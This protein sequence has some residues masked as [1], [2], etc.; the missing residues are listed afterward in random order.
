MAKN[1]KEQY[2]PT[3]LI[4]N[5]LLPDNPIMKRMLDLIRK[6]NIVGNLT[7]D[8]L[9]SLDKEL[10][11]EF[12]VFA[13]ENKNRLE[14]K[15]TKFGA[16]I[17]KQA[18]KRALKK[19]ETV[20]KLE[21]KAKPRKETSTSST[22]K[23][24]VKSKKERIREAKDL[25]DYDINSLNKNQLKLIITTAG[26]EYKR[27]E[28]YYG[29]YQEL[30]SKKPNYIKPK[31]IQAARALLTFNFS[32]KANPIKWIEYDHII[33]A[34]LYSAKMGIEYLKSEAP[35]ELPKIMSQV[36]KNL[37][38]VMKLLNYKDINEIIF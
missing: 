38:E 35:G 22:Q 12:R 15:Y 34:K 37:D 24:T 20:K 27:L 4:H 26:I 14:E 6:N 10:A 13:G 18:T 3:N 28:P 11:D 1:V 21:T 32:G 17:E 23:T 9:E 8:H 36:G 2:V 16:N 33:K 30:M 7:W 25:L 29:K 5:S 31:P 19:S